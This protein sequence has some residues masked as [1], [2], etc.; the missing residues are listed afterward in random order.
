M[1][2]KIKIKK[3]PRSRTNKIIGTQYQI[4]A[5][6]YLKEKKNQK[7]Y[8]GFREDQM[9]FYQRQQKETVLLGNRRT[10]TTIEETQFWAQNGERE[11]EMVPEK[12]ECQRIA[13]GDTRLLEGLR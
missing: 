6:K 13:L 11:R 4:N 9:R 3:W 8:K 5:K 7:R 12:K 10:E 2:I 1:K